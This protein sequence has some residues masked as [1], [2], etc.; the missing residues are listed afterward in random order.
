MRKLLVFSSLTLLLLCQLTV[1]ASAHDPIFLTSEHDKADTGPF[2]PDGTISFAFYGDLGSE[3]E[4]RGFQAV[5]QAGQT[6]Q[7]SMLIPAALP[8]TNLPF[9]DLPVLKVTRPDGTFFDLAAEMS[10]EFYEPYTGTT[11]V[12][13]NEFREVAQ[14]GV[15]DFILNGNV[16]ARFVVSIGAIERFGTP[17]KR[18]ARPFSLGSG[19]DP[20]TQW[21]SN[22]PDQKNET[23]ER[24]AEAENTTENKSEPL[25]IEEVVPQLDESETT[26]NLIVFL[27]LGI[28]VTSFTVWR[29]IRRL[30]RPQETDC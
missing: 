10:V 23:D 16:A 12:R 19:S 3:K 1:P 21:F 20:L 28:A 5:F 29:A 13:V 24:P 15:H 7:I 8:E 9:E 26:P 27:T 11:Y 2:L 14:E 22:A 4:T 6:L 18:Y 25:E 17:V 30:K